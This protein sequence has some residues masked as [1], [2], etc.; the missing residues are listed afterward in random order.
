MVQA[1]WSEV[2]RLYLV[3]AGE[4]VSSEGP[5]DGA[6]VDERSL[7][8]VGTCQPGRHGREGVD[9]S[10]GGGFQKEAQSRTRV[11]RPHSCAH[12]PSSPVF[13]LWKLR[14]SSRVSVR[15][16]VTECAWDGTGPRAPMF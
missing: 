14:S 13:A 10:V 9:V 12:S 11:A 8:G 4:E 3:T 16:G 7:R 6:V 15:L 1:Q 2:S 5:A